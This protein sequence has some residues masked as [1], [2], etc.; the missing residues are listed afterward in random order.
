MNFLQNNI[1]L[2]FLYGG[3]IFTDCKVKKSTIQ[4]DN[5]LTTEYLFPDGLKVTNIATKYPYGYEWVNYFENTSDKPT[6]IISDIYDCDIKLPL[7]KEK[8]SSFPA[9]QTDFENATYVISSSGSTASVYDF[10]SFPDRIEAN[11][12][13]GAL[14]TNSTRNFSATNGR[15]SEGTAPFFNIHSN[16]EGYIVAIGWTGQWHCKITRNPDDVAI[17]TGV[18][19]TH[20]KLLPHEKIRTSSVV[21]MPY[22]C[23][24]ISSQN[25]WRKFVKEHFSLIG[26]DKKP[27]LC[28]SVWGGLKSEKILERIDIIKKYNLPFE[29]IWTDAGWY[30]IDAKPTPDEF[31]SD[32]GDHTGDWRVSPHIHPNSLCDVSEKAH[33]ANLKFL[34][35][36]EVE[37]VSKNSP[38][39][40]KHPEY[41]LQHK[42]PERPDLLLNLGDENAWKYCFETISE[43]IEKSLF[44]TLLEKLHIIC[45]SCN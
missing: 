44:L 6:E 8:S 22:K 10:S 3:M 42:N 39:M 18:E 29:Y 9:Y 12:F 7:K 33:E 36:F 41:F 15:S 4:K 40:K 37:R 32:W 34:L 14:L 13:E 20:F 38:V 2:S 28:A 23:D 19:N 21:L 45:T 27:P 17:K 16:N 26:K 30:G 25:K 5:M 1:R 11:Q 35:W 43:I 24:V 31:E